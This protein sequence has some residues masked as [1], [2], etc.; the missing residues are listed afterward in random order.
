[1][2]FRK[3]RS[4]TMQKPC[5][6]CSHRH[7]T[8]SRRLVIRRFRDISEKFATFL[9]QRSRSFIPQKYRTRLF[10]RNTHL[11]CTVYYFRCT[12]TMFLYPF[13]WPPLKKRYGLMFLR[14]PSRNGL[15]PC[16]T[17]N[18]TPRRREAFCLREDLHGWFV[19]QTRFSRRQKQG[20]YEG[21]ERESK[22]WNYGSTG[23][24]LEHSV[25]YTHLHQRCAAELLDAAQVFSFIRD[26]LAFHSRGFRYDFWLCPYYLETI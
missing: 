19:S 10:Q 11:H 17:M 16:E 22:L 23:L 20:K 13:L 6:W 3:P 1:M 5:L 26:M 9:H 7:Q 8:T 21:R 12:A 18:H 15:P 2:K 4:K 14:R 25:D 24:F